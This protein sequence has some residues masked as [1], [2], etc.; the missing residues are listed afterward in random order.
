MFV[1]RDSRQQLNELFQRHRDLNFNDLEF[2]YLPVGD[3]MH[4]QRWLG[5]FRWKGTSMGVSEETTTKGEAKRSAAEL[6][7]H[8]MRSIGYY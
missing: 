8:Y 2:R 1:A 3:N 4:N 5:E 6:A 7:V